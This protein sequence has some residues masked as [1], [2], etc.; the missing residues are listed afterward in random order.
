MTFSCS[1]SQQVATTF[2]SS[3][4]SF[5]SLP[6]TPSAMGGLAVRFQFRTWNP[7]GLLLSTLLAQEP[8]RLELQ[9]SNSR[10]RLTH[11]TSD[12][13]KSEV[14]TGED[15][16][17]ACRSQPAHTHPDNPGIERAQN[18]KGSIIIPQTNREARSVVP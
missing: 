7:D 9:I 15:Q 2:L 8:R 3:S 18:I 5:L 14:S 13:Q 12:Q 16:P 11:H 1:E 4:S 6:A 10:L 17:L